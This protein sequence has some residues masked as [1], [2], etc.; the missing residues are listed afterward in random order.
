MNIYEVDGKLGDQLMK[1]YDRLY[2]VIE[3]MEQ[4][5]EEDWSE[6]MDSLHRRVGQVK[7]LWEFVQLKEE[8]E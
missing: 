6:H 3:A 8:E 5:E 7:H 1:V 2:L 4:I